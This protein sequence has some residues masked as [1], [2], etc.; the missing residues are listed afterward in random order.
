M[1]FKKLRNTIIFIL[2][3]CGILLGIFMVY[4]GAQKLTP[5]DPLYEP[6]TPPFKTF[7]AGAG[8]IEASSRNIEMGTLYSGLVENIYI[9]VN[10]KVKK[11]DPLFRLDDTQ[12]KS[13]LTFE[14]TQ[15]DVLKAQIQKAH[16]DLKEAQDQL[17]RAKQLK[18]T[19]SLSKEAFE[20]RAFQ[21]KRI[22]SDLVILA[23]EI[24]QSE[25]KIS[26]LKTRID[27]YTVRAPIDGTILQVN[28]LKGEYASA[29][30]EQSVLIVMGAVDTYHVRVDI[31]EFDVWRLET[32]KRA[33]GYP[34][35][36]PFTQI[37]LTFVR[38]DPYI[39]PKVNLTSDV[40]E[41]VDTRVLQLIY[42]FEPNH[43]PIYVGQQLDVDIETSEKYEN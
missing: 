34:R 2:A 22:E 33:I 3:G 11:D 39:I 43:Y 30:S 7:V 36:D 40:S 14:L 29:S 18:H 15:I 17:T 13:E 21:V 38:I 8:I 16:I 6:Q 35:G 41:R 12:L 4:S 32:D 20:T 1:N 37:P 31:D 28:T 19:S 26:D 42:S 27:L 5:A 25:K 24:L 10:D 23:K 9:H